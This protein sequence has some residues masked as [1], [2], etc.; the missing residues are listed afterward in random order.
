TIEVHLSNIHAR[1]RFRHKSYISPVALGVICG[2]GAQGYLLALDALASHLEQ[3][4]D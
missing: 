2:L 4:H 3:K 1:E